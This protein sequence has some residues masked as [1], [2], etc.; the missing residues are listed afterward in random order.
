MKK[1]WHN[2][3]FMPF[4]PVRQFY[5]KQSVCNVCKSF[6]SQIQTARL[7]PKATLPP[8]KKIHPSQPASSHHTPVWL[9]V[10]ARIPGPLAAH[11]CEESTGCPRYCPRALQCVHSPGWGIETRDERARKKGL[12][13]QCYGLRVLLDEDIKEVN[14]TLSLSQ[15][16][17]HRDV[18][19]M[20]F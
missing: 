20:V 5:S 15:Y 8:R 2:Q 14:L 7:A 9:S 3:K 1:A 18:G 4:T 17:L 11:S 19:V 16:S 10:P 12:E 6:L 13:K